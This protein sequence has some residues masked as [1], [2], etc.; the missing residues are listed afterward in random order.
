M[1]T[2][3]QPSGATSLTLRVDGP[4]VALP[5]RYRDDPSDDVFNPTLTGEGAAAVKK[6][7]RIRGSRILS[8]ALTGSYLGGTA[9]LNTDVN[10]THVETVTEAGFDQV[11][12]LI[13]NR[14]ASAITYKAS[15]AAASALG[16][17]NS[18]ATIDPTL[19][20]GS[21]VDCT[22]VG[23]TGQAPAFTNSIEGWA[24]TNWMDL[25]SLD[26]SDGGSLS[27][28]HAR[29][30][31]TAGTTTYTL[32]AALA[33][34]AGWESVSAT[35]GRVWRARTQAVDGVTTK[36][37]F[38]S[39][40]SAPQHIPFII[41]YLSR[42]TGASIYVHGDSRLDGFG[43]TLTGMSAT[44]RAAF[45]LSTPE[46]PIEVCNMGFSGAAGITIYRRAISQAAGLALMTFL[47]PDVVISLS[48]FVNDNA[49]A[50][51]TPTEVAS[52][53]RWWGSGQQI[54]ETT[55]AARIVCTAH[56]APTRST[57]GTD[58]ALR[59]AYSNE[60]AANID[61][62]GIEKI[63]LRAILTS[64]ALDANGR[65]TFKPGYSDDLLHPNETGYAAETPFFTT[66][67]KN[68]L[69]LT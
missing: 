15:I 5:V 18:A 8:K 45:Q 52:Y 50:P 32:T 3:T 27:I 66:A 62:A 12:L 21:W 9:R 2:N 1:G 48:D 39:T 56:P 31:A 46:F 26:R 58:D 65:E 30:E 43:A 14:S 53:R 64:T 10:T 23:G 55:K 20:G 34:L 60:V 57:N 37:N 49:A 13:P 63:D 24:V 69:G 36:G 67:L 68:V 61:K 33:S 28:L 4:D 29:V 17:D 7:A 22:F 54:T 16:A 59:I 38:T 40:A 44:M 47:N 35:S 51:L 42:A 25:N 41:Q 6:A 19:N 11:R